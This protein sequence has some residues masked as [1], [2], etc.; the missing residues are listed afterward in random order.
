M[1]QRATRDVHRLIWL[2]SLLSVTA[3]AGDTRI[4]TTPFGT[5]AIVGSGLVKYRN[6][7]IWFRVVFISGDF[8]K[9]LQEHK[10]RDGIEFRE[11]KSKTVYATFPNPLIVDLEATPWECNTAATTSLTP[12]DYAS[13]VLEAPSFDVAWKRGDESRQVQLLASEEHHHSMG[14]GWSYLLNVPSAD[15]P[16]TDSL[17]ID[18]SM[19]GGTCR[20]RL[21]ANLDDRQRP[22]IPSTCDWKTKDQV[23]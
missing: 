23:R 11:K 4:K 6:A 9:D 8:F 17:V 2:I 20:T 15:V 18:I 22:V 5:G 12:P 13:G 7:C 16:L 1:S 21:T 3:T 14:L 19:R 10:T